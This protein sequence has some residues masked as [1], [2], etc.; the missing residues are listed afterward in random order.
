MINP[1][2]TQVRSTIAVMVLAASTL[3]GMS[4]CSQVKTNLEALTITID[5][6]LM[7]EIDRA[8][9]PVLNRVWKSGRQENN[10]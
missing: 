9:E 2:P 10:A 3:V 6:A 8:V 7:A 5:P 1:S 4:R